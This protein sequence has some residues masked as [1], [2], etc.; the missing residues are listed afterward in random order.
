MVSVNVT[1]PFVMLG[2]YV[3]VSELALEKVPL[4]AVHVELVALPPIE[5][6][7]VTALPA[8]IG[9]GA[10]PAFAVAA[11]LIVSVLEQLL[12]HTSE[13]TIVTV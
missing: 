3:E 4:G 2:V 9:G 10:V 12:W 11:G 1:D 7:N 6:F 8:Q 13:F 5:P